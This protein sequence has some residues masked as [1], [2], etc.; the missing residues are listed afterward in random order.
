MQL[1]NLQQK[2]PLS[3]QRLDRDT[4]DTYR[5]YNRYLQILQQLLNVVDQQRKSDRGVTFR[6]ILLQKFS[7]QKI[8]LGRQRLDRDITVV[9]AVNF[10]HII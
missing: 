8:S 1:T 7:Q 5:E 2:I 4:T 3:R 10:S 9:I 6:L